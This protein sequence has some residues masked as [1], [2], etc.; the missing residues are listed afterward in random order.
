[1]DRVVTEELKN[2]TDGFEETEGENS[3]NTVFVF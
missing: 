3:K 1:M 2:E